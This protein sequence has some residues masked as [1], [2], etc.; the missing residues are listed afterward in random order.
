M[1]ER[2]NTPTNPEWAKTLKPGWQYYRNRNFTALLDG[3][4]LEDDQVR[5]KWTSPLKKLMSL[6]HGGKSLRRVIVSPPL[7]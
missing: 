2:N 5:D 4:Q 1:D 7:E 3:V 6:P